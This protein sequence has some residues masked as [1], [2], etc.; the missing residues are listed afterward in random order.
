MPNMEKEDGLLDV[1]TLGCVLELS[2]A[3][4][5]D[6]Y[7]PGYN[8]DLAENWQDFSEESQARTWYRV[9]MKMFAAN[10]TLILQGMLVHPSYLWQYLLVRFAAAIY[11][12]MGAPRQLVDIVEGRTRLAVKEALQK[13]FRED[14]PHLEAPFLSAIT[15][16]KKDRTSM[17]WEGGPI[18]IK[19][20]TLIFQQILS[21]AQMSEILDLPQFPLYKPGKDR[22][23]TRVNA[24]YEGEWIDDLS[25]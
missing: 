7:A 15:E 20:K 3:L 12:H 4:T 22:G 23:M 17:T 11:T 25:N 24:Y 21:A 8:P 1:I 14:H 6:R 19:A 5:R 16:D 13:H 10:Y 9:I 18:R 2:D